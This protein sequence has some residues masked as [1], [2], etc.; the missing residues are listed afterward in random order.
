M[1]GVVVVVVISILIYRL[2]VR[3]SL[4]Q[5]D[6]NAEEASLITAVTAASINLAA[7]MLLSYLYKGLAGKPP[8]GL[9]CLLFFFFEL[10]KKGV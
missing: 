1:I 6:G 4:F 2:A 7:I 9:V 10:R 5:R 8:P 3:A